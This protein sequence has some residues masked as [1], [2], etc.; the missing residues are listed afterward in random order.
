MLTGFLLKVIAPWRRSE[1]TIT[2]V[3]EAVN[4][5]IKVVSAA[6]NIESDMS[7]ATPQ[8]VATHIVN[9]AL[10]V[11]ELN[12][13]IGSKTSHV[14]GMGVNIQCTTPEY[15]EIVESFIKKIGKK[16]HFEVT[17]RLGINEF[18]KT[19][20]DEVTRRGGVIVRKHINKNWKYKVKFEIV[21][22][23]KIDY[24]K[25]EPE[26]RLFN[27][28]QLDEYGARTGLWFLDTVTN[29]SDFVQA[30]DLIIWIPAWVDST[31]YTP[32]SKLSS[33]MPLL[34]MVNEYRSAEVKTATKKA[35]TP[36]VWQTSLY[37]AQ[38]EL[39][40]KPTTAQ[41]ALAG[42]DEVKKSFSDMQTKLTDQLR[43]KESD[44]FIVPQDD[45]V[46]QW[47]HDASGIY[48][49]LDQRAQM[50]IAAGSGLS[51][52]ITFKNPK[53]VNY[54][55]LR[56]FSEATLKES[57]SEFNDFCSQVMDDFMK[58][59]E[60]AMVLSNELPSKF[61][62]DDIDLEYEFAPMG[63]YIDID[64]AKTEQANKTGL[65][66]GT[67]TLAEIAANRGWRAEDIIKQ[68]AEEQA[69]QEFELKEARKKLGLPD[70]EE[71]ANSQIDEQSKIQQ[72]NKQT[73]LDKQAKY[74]QDLTAMIEL[75]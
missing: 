26:K 55:T 46:T 62:V 42:A 4:P 51:A 23:A 6:N 75:I 33:V 34:S 56:A 22:V 10:K 45:K 50:Q 49:I 28:Q 9:A 48:D 25:H 27:G 11:P 30:E 41:A 59:V 31:Q 54:S 20:R 57:Q 58:W 64:P 43:A 21:N 2:D 32:Y 19:L 24:S 18:F 12:A 53:D 74:F 71:I 35:N 40:R 16:R 37:T 29:K 14:L 17:G 1:P 60:E 52:A 70:Y 47:S 36:A 72:T 67:R 65:E 66:N 44:F 8:G 69:L 5:D 7:P 13:L 68:R 63:G 15:A 39:M 61:I 73:S 3:K 38:M